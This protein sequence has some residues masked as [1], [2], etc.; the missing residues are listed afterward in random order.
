MSQIKIEIAVTPGLSCLRCRHAKMV[1]PENL[2][3]IRCDKQNSKVVDVTFCCEIAN[4]NYLGKKKFANEARTPDKPN[5]G[6]DK[7]RA[8]TPLEAAY[9]ARYYATAP[10]EQLMFWTQRTW[11]CLQSLASLHGVAVRPKDHRE[12]GRRSMETRRQRPEDFKLWT[13]AQDA[14]L[15]QVYQTDQYPRCGGDDLCRERNRQLRYAVLERVNQLGP[16]RTWGAVKVRVRRWTP[17]Y[18]RWKRQR[19]AQGKRA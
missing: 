7:L 19:L 16:T 13:P 1:A 17:G 3:V 6:G 14:Y 12:I 11:T 8:V 4:P 2:T 15:K 10:R 5:W 18:Q 9:I